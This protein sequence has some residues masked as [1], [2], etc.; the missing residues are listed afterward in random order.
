VV[1]DK[2]G[3]PVKVSRPMRRGRVNG[4]FMKSSKLSI[5]SNPVNWADTFIPFKNNIKRCLVLKP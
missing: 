3:N 4:D 2:D 5:N 1:N